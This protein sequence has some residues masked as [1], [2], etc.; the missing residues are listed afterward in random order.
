MDELKRSRGRRYAL[1]APEAR[2]YCSLSDSESKTEANTTTYNIDKRIAGGTGTQTIVS[3]DNS[4]V[5]VT[6][7]GAVQAAFGFAKEAFN[8]AVGRIGDSTHEA[9]AAV[10]S[11]EK[12]LADAYATAKAGEQKVLVG[13]GLVI[14]G[15]VAVAALR[16][17]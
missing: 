1:D 9:I 2:R 16:R 5:T 15:L 17:G 6:D 4:T 13:A 12:D 14:V 10:Q 8:A 7:G 11:S 3:A